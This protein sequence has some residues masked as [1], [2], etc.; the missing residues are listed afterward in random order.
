MNDHGRPTTMV[1]HK[2]PSS[3][4]LMSLRKHGSYTRTNMVVPGQLGHFIAEQGSSWLTMVNN[5][6]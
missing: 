5:S 6:F 3:K 2:L 1:D 4:T